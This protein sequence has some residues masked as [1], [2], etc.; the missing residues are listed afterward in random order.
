MTRA[1]NLSRRRLLAGAAGAVAAATA[2]RFP[3]PRR[4]RAAT[5]GPREV[6]L[7]D[8]RHAGGKL[9]AGRALG[10]RVT[11]T[12]VIGP[13]RF[14]G[15]VAVSPF[16]FTHAGLH[17]ASSG[18]PE[19]AAFEVRTSADGQGWTG[20]EPVTVESAS[21]DDDSGETF[22]A[23]VSAPRHRFLQY[24][25]TLRGGSEVE[26]VTTTF[27]N[28]L[29]GQPLAAM[30]VSASTAEIPF[31]IQTREDWLAKDELRF[32]TDGEIWPR[33]YVPVKKAVV[34][35]TATSN[36]YSDA[37]AE[38]RSIYTYHAVSQGWGD[39]GY[40][41][42]IDKNGIIYE[43]RYGRDLG[44]GPDGNPLREALSQG[45]VAGHALSHNY[46]STG[47]AFLGTHTKKGDGGKPGVEPS[48]LAMTSL[49]DILEFELGRNNIDPLGVSD[50]LRSNETWNPDLANV[51]GH[52][53]CTSTICPGGHLY[54]KL[55]QLRIDL[56]TALTASRSANLPGGAAPPVVNIG[57]FEPLEGTI[58]DDENTS[59]TLAYDWGGTGTKY[60]YALEA[61]NRKP[62]PL[63]EDIDYIA[64][65][66][67]TPDHH[68]DWI[69]TDATS[70]GPFS[71][72]ANSTPP[73]RHYTFHVR[74][75]ILG[76]DGS[77]VF[78]Y[79]D[80]RSHLLV[81]GAP[82]PPPPPPTPVTLTADGYKE[83]GRQK[84]SLSWTW[85][86]EEIVAVF[87]FRDG[88]PLPDGQPVPIEPPDTT[89]LDEIDKKGG[90]SYSYQLFKLLEDGATLSAVSNEA[91]VNF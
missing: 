62:A 33:M 15:P 66:G 91:V 9:A 22:A 56:D 83:K 67:F 57:A 29:D 40:N 51:S 1:K 79:Q 31:G 58:E 3:G 46:G 12:G 72:D 36:N 14:E 49:E 64:S 28:S 7:H 47:I 24:R 84:V 18:G 32:D 19:A 60:W 48:N 21:R 82:T 44:L 70:A 54:D 23:L 50:F 35:H 88:L 77:Y 53:D 10:A 43:G 71:G 86:S 38:I 59:I 2:M 80:H 61:W 26:A 20:W 63:N 41:A 73:D 45:I 16:P 87:L 68:L 42:L 4:S 37:A 6:L 17:W 76:E 27:L 11:T 90:G 75:G 8:D 69:E 25:G 34:H 81:P 74:A 89:Y 65:E 13:G 39:I 85:T 5:Q 30:S 55:V 78:S 52:R